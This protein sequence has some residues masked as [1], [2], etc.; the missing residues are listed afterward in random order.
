M[1]DQKVQHRV[2][3]RVRK[4]IKLAQDAGATEGE[5]DN[6]MRMVH[7]TLAKY[8]LS[9]SQV[10]GEQDAANEK[11][12][13]FGEAFLG[14][15]WCIQIAGAI[16]RLYFCGYFYRTIG[17]NAGPTQKAMHCFVGRESNVTTAREMARF[18][19]EEVNRE[20]QRYQRSIGGKYGDYR[21]FAQAA[22]E[23]IRLRCYRLQ[24]ES[25]TKGVQG[26]TESTDTAP[27]KLTQHEPGTALV[28]A[29]LYKTEEEANETYTK[30]HVGEL[31]TG[32]SQTYAEGAHAR[33]AGAEFGSK[34]SL[35]RQVKGKKES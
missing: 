34:V 28:L 17:G 13:N 9:L 2:L 33:R 25:S 15:P 8:N 23:R 11:R 31:R 27:A 19:V 35:H 20:A 18:V 22:A 1:T 16:A 29:S 32:R 5:R 3:A 24:Q 10:G 12:T 6:A 21:A 14:K 4:M 30:K 26:V 7:A